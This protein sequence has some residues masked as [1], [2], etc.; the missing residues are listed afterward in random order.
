MK[1]VILL[2][3]LTGCTLVGGSSKDEDVSYKYQSCALVHPHKP[4]QEEKYQCVTTAR[5][6]SIEACKLWAA[7]EAV[8][9]PETHNSG[10]IR[11][12]CE[13]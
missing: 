12:K 3:C 9:N 5:F 8:R 7:S 10:V 6:D 4:V 11:T 13:E 1:S 2:F